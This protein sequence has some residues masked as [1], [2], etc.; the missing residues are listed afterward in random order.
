M[1]KEE[2]EKFIRYKTVFNDK[3]FNVQVNEISKFNS[4]IFPNS[5]RHIGGNSEKRE[6]GSIEIIDFIEFLERDG[7][8]AIENY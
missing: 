8:K 3:G 1:N 4:Y 7:G 6:N 5:Y 2:L